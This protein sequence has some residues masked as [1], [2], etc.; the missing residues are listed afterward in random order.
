MKLCRMIFID[1]ISMVWIMIDAISSGEVRYRRGKIVQNPLV[2]AFR[3]KIMFSAY[4]WRGAFA[5]RRELQDRD[6]YRTGLGLAGRCL[7]PCE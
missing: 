4:E 7:T 3:N 5:L 6:I 1:T 2:V